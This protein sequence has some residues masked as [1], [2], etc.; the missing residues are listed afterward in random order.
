M[1]SP[2]KSQHD[3]DQVSP[4]E[5]LRHVKQISEERDRE[6]RKRAADLEKDIQQ[7]REQRRKRR[8]GKCL[9]TAILFD[10]SADSLVLSSTYRPRSL[11]L[12]HFSLPRELL[13]TRLSFT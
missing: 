11:P 9:Y 8:A 12:Q 10:S 3:L 6:D 13:T 7:S 2:E 4:E 5:F 1:S